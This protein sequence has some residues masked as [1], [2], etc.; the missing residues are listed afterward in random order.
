VL[1][2]ATEIP[3]DPIRSTYELM[4]LAKKW[5]GGSPYF[6]VP[7]AL[8][9]TPKD[10][11][12]LEANI[13][14]TQVA[15]GSVNADGCSLTGLRM[16]RV[17]N[18]KFLWTTEIVGNKNK[19]DVFWVSIRVYCEATGSILELPKA[20]KPV[21]VKWIVSENFGTGFDADI[22]VSSQPLA[23]KTSDLD[24]VAKILSGDS[25]NRLPVVY[26]SAGRANHP[27]VDCARL[28]TDLSGLAHVLVEPSRLFA[29]RLMDKV[30]GQNAY[31]GAIGVYW[32][33]GM[34]RLEKFLEQAYESPRL[35]EQAVVGYVEQALAN[36]RPTPSCTWAYLSETIS[37]KTI[38]DLRAT[39][40]TKI[41]DYVAAFDA[42]IS[43]KQQQLDTAENEINRLKAEVRKFESWAK[44]QGSSPLVDGKERDL[45]QGE[46]RGLLIEILREALTNNV[47][48]DSRRGHII[49]DIIDANNADTP[50]TALADKIKECLRNYSSMTR[51]VR[52]SLEDIGFEITEDGK[53]YK[54]IF[55]YDKRY[56]FA[57]AKTPSDN[58]AGL[59]IGGE[60]RRKLF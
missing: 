51:T 37:R 56:A 7:K 5:L 25:K 42:E 28:S 14:N 40:S 26:V 52:K 9:P 39:G 34:G 41:D 44:S 22:K 23:L 30:D 49:S 17:E 11:E 10:G 45:Y 43:A 21:F 20:K 53:H 2:F 31:S 50:S 60:I 48:P 55:M 1:V 19:T 29:R 33:A 16:S 18:N 54:L 24:W 36:R 6:K 38:I 8:I 32:S 47:H 58:R 15:V 46:R 3:V 12:I 57:V 13:G 4:A 27:S 59:N 35:M